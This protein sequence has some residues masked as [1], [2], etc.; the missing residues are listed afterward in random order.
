MNYQTELDIYELTLADAQDEYDS[1]IDKPDTKKSYL[2]I[3]QMEID[4]AKKM[5]RK[6]SEKINE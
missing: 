2:E 1:L 4:H 5:I 6:F 3:L